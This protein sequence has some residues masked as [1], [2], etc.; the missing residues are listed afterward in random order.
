VGEED[1]LLFLEDAL[2]H[3]VSLF[4]GFPICHF[5]EVHFGLLSFPLL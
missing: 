1:L 5:V 2:K 3:L 4:E